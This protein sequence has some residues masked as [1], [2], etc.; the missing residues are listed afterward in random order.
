MKRAVPPAEQ[1]QREVTVYV[2]F[3]VWR[4]VVRSYMFDAACVSSLDFSVWG[5]GLLL[6]HEAEEAHNPLLLQ[7][8]ATKHHPRL[9]LDIKKHLKSV[10]KWH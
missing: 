7:W 9:K 8:L 2:R 10:R 5:P 4:V 1:S 3:Y 6:P